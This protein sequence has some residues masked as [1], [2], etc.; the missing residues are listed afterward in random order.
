MRISKI[1]I[2]HLV[3]PLGFDL[4]K[5]LHI[6]AFLDE[7]VQT[8]EIDRRLAIKQGEEVVYD[9]GWE[10]ATDL[11]FEDVDLALVPRSRYM[12]EV[13]AKINGQELAETSYFETGYLKEKMAGDWIGT[14]KLDLHSL[15]LEKKFTAETVKNARL[16]VSGVGLFE[17]YLDGQ[18]VGDEYLAPGF[19]DYR[20]YVQRASYDV[21]SLVTPG[22]HLLQIVLAD[23]WYR[24]K[25]GLAQHG[26]VPDNYGSELKAIADLRLVSA[27]GEEVIATDDSWDVVTSPVTHSGIYYGEDFDETISRQVLEKAVVKQAPGKYLLDR[28]SLPI[29]AHEEFIPRVI[30][31]QSGDQVLD[32]GQN[33]AGWVEFKNRLPKGNKVT[34]DF[35]EIMQDGEFYR[36]NLRS[37]RAQFTYVSGGEEKWIRP[38]FTYFGFRYAK[39]TGWSGDLTASDFKAVALYSDM[40]ETGNIQTDN[41][42]VNRLFEN[43]KWGQKSNFVDVPTDCPQRDERLGW[44]GDAAIFALTAS[45]NMDTYQFNK[46]FSYDIAVEQ[47]RLAGKVPLYVPSVGNDDGGKAVWS[48]AAT[49]IPWVSYQRSGDKAILRQN[50]GAMMSWVD[51]VHDRALAN[52]NEHL[53]LGDDQLGD[54]LALDTEDIMKLKGKTPDDLI[55][56]AYYYYS[57]KIV[58]QAAEV[59]GMKHEY[60]YYRQ[61]SRLIKEAFIKHF[62]TPDGLAIANTQTGLAL[63]LEFGLYPAAAK[64][65]L[66]NSLVTKIEGN[67]NHLDTG[68]VGTP[69]LLPALTHNGQEQLA[70]RLFLNTDFPSWLYEVKKGATTIWERWNSVE[71]DGHIAKNGM[72]S[73]NH[74]SS[75]AVMAWAYEDLVGLTQAGKNVI[76]KPLISSKFKE[77]AGQVMLPTGLVKASVKL[78]KADQVTILLEIPL[79]SQVKLDL[80]AGQ[81]TVNGQAF[82][83]ELLKSGS[84]TLLLQLEAPIVEACDV[85]TP[86][87]E[88]AS[89]AALTEKLSKLV[90]FWGFLTIPGNLDHF[91]QYSLFQLSREMRGIGFK[92]FED[93]DIESINQ[94]F[95]EYALGE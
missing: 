39:L 33:L 70:L 64:K 91:G 13:A 30:M 68:F 81:M 35:G 87:K 67:R 3:K 82:D 54:W 89:H 29:T 47:S 53:W 75:G 76:F 9:S 14:S 77:V 59:L 79:G 6:A 25:L 58:S 7:A 49:I 45:Y 41:A 23:G 24:G 80:P 2:N 42:E 46:K 65:G 15:I 21:T 44:T 51:W 73:L 48:D 55:A 26:G 10:A 83:G 74:Y 78:E 28:R 34:I 40:A 31:T 56:S 20:Y 27:D 66:V 8:N 50:I 1:E 52:G 69:L 22:N 57:A 92:P 19:T 61:L 18:K 85:H 4:G 32:F 62:Y 43:V 84:Y 71:E 94:V 38:H 72:N 12:V 88:F 95:K 16:Y 86:L 37:A 11:I 63:C 60:Q 5:K 17:A 93:K 90:P 36:D